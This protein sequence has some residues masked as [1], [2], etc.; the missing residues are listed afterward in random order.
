MKKQLFLLLFSL[1]A[2][3]GY[4]R[5]VT[6]TVTQASDGEPITGASVTVKGVKGG[7]VTDIDGKY[8]INVQGDNA[9][10]QFSFVGMKP[11]EEKVGGR[12]VVDVQMHENSE[13]LSEVVVTTMGQSQEK[14]KLNFSVQ[15]LKADDVTAGQSANFVNSLQGKVSGLQVSN[16]GGS[17][18]AASQIIIRGVSSVNPSQSNEPLF[19]VDGMPIRGGGSSMADLNPADIESMSV[20]KGAAA[21]ALYGQEGSNGVILITTKSGKDGKVTVTVNGG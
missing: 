19:V 9:V 11:V 21:S 5:V 3:T 1:L 18:N 17:P 16:G 8:T 14:S 13:M 12:S 20:L 2:L 7:A 6:G 15:E 10:L 4:A